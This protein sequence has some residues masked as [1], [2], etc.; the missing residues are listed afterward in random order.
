MKFT[1]FLICLFLIGCGP[2]I[3][4]DKAKELAESLLDQ[5]KTTIPAKMHDYYTEEFLSETPSEVWASSLTYV[6]D[7]IGKV[8]SYKLTNSETT[9]ASGKPA[10]AKLYYDVKHSKYNSKH[11]FQVAFEDGKYRIKFHRIDPDSL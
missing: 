7:S 1:P 9:R 2:A 4:V 11:T 3:E 10:T 8:V 6:T 5:M